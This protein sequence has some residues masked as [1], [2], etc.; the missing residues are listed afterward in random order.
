MVLADG[1]LVGSGEWIGRQLVSWHR[2]AGQAGLL[3]VLDGLAAGGGAE[4]AVD[5]ERLALDR[6]LGD[7][8]SLA[9]LSEGQVGREQGQ[10]PQFSRGQRDGGSGCLEEPVELGLHLSGLGRERKLEGQAVPSKS[11]NLRD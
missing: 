1:L 5:R 6:V 4:F 9:Y 3:D 8:E 7:V 11:E 2:R 10:E